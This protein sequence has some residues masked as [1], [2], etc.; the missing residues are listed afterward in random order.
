MLESANQIIEKLLVGNLIGKVLLSE[1]DA[2]VIDPTGYSIVNITQAG[3]AETRGLAN[4]VEGQFL[5]MICTVYAADVVVTPSA[6]A[7]TTITFNAA[8][9]SWI[10][11]FFGGE[12]HTIASAAITGAGGAV[13]A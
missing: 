13:V 12:W 10:G 11:V 2:E 5:V 6:L 3:A 8:G 1:T 7:G 4:G 9:D